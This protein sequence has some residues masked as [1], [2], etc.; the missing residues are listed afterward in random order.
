[1]NEYFSSSLIQKYSTR[2]QEYGAT[3]KG[4]FWVSKT[5]QELRFEII[6]REVKKI[7]RGSPIEIADI[8]C[9]YGALANYLSLRN[10]INLLSYEGYDISPKLVNECNVGILEQI[11]DCPEMSE[12]LDG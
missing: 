8:G 12:T 6:L 5:R 7:S 10:D 9:G 1:M 11:W 3:P 2:F 4:S